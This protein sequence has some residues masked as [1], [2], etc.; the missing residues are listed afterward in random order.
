[1]FT[2][3]S[4]GLFNEMIDDGSARGR[5]CHCEEPDGNRRD[6]RSRLNNVLYYTSPSE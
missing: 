2:I 3:K 1:M 6:N 5:Y 4:C